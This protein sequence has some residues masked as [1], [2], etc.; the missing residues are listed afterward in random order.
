MLC[1]ISAALAGTLTASAI[2]ASVSTCLRICGMDFSHIGRWPP[3]SSTIFGLGI[4]AGVALFWWTGVPEVGLIAAAVVKILLP[5][6]R[7]GEEENP[8]DVVEEV[9]ETLA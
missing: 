6:H 4:L 5:Q 3:D 9:A 2:L 7:S 1:R 8:I